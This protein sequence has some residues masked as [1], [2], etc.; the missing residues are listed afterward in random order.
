MW[1]GKSWH[2]RERSQIVDGGVPG[3]WGGDKDGVGCLRCVPRPALGTDTGLGN[4]RKWNVRNRV[5][6]CR[7]S[8]SLSAIVESLRGMQN[9]YSVV[10]VN[11][12]VILTVS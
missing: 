11:I 10:L 6:V 9:S 3:Q 1:A 4:Q 8:G 5:C 2:G 12:R 7:H